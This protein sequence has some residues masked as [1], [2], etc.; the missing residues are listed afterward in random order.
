M[1]E[2]K[3]NSSF[4]LAFCLTAIFLTII[5][6]TGIFA[7]SLILNQNQAAMAQQQQQQQRLL[8]GSQQSSNQT[9]SHAKQLQQPFVSKGISFDIDNV[10]FSHHMASVNGGVQIHYVIGGQGQP[11]VLLHGWPQTWYEWRHVMP[12]LA[13]NHTVIVPD[14]RGLG[15]SSKPLTGYDGKTVAE[16]I[17]QLVSQLRFKQIFLVGH[18][19][20]VQVAYSY[21]AA[22]PNDVR[23][24]VILDVPIPGIGRGQNITGLWWVQFHMVRDIPEMLVNGHEREYL[25]W[26]YRHTCN[27]TAITKEDI[28]EYVNHY[29]APG[30]MRAGFEYYRALF[31]DIKQNKE[32]S[33]VKLPMPVLALGGEC[34]FGTAALDSMRLLATD[35]RGGV[36]PD[37][38]HWIAEE[39]PDF[40]V[41]QLFKFFG[42]STTK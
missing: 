25:T 5:I 6:A 34:S 8:L 37:S 30:G 19:F 15:D 4:Y 32:Y 27:P 36:V 38:G 29:S 20:G 10:T 9:I 24:L 39:R 16:D 40:V 26:F 2:K 41:D 14:L 12:S 17:H 35:V 31:D 23:R 18:D 21:A 33:R 7:I 11:V 3:D 13:K 1:N 22:H 28:D 42:S